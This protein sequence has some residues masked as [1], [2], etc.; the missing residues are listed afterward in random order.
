[1]PL[2][3]H[4]A[5]QPLKSSSNIRAKT[6]KKIKRSNSLT[7]SYV[8]NVISLPETED[9]KEYFPENV[10]IHLDVGLNGA[11]DCIT[12]ICFRVAECMLHTPRNGKGNHKLK[13]Y[14]MLY[15]KE[16]ITTILK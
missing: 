16:R 15:K 12:K 1:M 2:V 4:F 3:G 11:T 5:C 9:I 14:G 6:V 13:W 8:E 10:N 7:P